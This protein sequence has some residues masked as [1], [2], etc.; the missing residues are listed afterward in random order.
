MLRTPQDSLSA[1]RSAYEQDD[2]GL[3]LHTVA[4]PV[5]K[6][7]SEYTIRLGWDQLRPQVGKLVAESKI[8]EVSDYVTPG[9]D[10]AA[11][12]ENI[13]PKDGVRGKRVRLGVKGAEEDFLFLQE[14][15]PPP[16]GSKQASG[17]WIGDRYFTK[18]EHRSL[19][20]YVSNDVPEKDR[21]HW[22][23]V[24]PFYPFQKDGQIA[25]L[26]KQEIARERK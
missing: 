23:L 26:L 10:A 7:Y 8:V 17:V 3:F 13:W 6:R 25:A 1:M 16:Q 4:A 9:I 24:F 19:G 15:D 21:T 18:R 20:T 11:P 22:R 2:V 12:P 5:L 14:V